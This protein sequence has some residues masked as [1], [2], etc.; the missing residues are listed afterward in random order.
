VRGQ[1]KAQTSG[2]RQ[3][4]ENVHAAEA[5]PLIELQY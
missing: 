4:S 5:T 1:E 3:V 2:G